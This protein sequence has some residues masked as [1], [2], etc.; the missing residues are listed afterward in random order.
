MSRKALK[1]VAALAAQARLIN[2]RNL[3]MRLPVPIPR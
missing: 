1:P 2:D 3:N